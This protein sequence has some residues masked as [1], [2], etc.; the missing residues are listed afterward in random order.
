MMKNELYISDCLYDSDNLFDIP[1]LRADMQAGKLELPLVAFGAQRRTLTEARTIHFYVEDYRFENIWK[2]P[3]KIVS[4][5]IASIVEPNVSVFDTTPIAYGLHQIYKKRWIARYWQECGI[6]V[7]ADLNVSS[8]FYEYNLMGI[9]EGYNAFA[10]RGYADRLQYMEAEIEQA[11]RI[12][13]LDMPNMIVYGGGSKVHELCC[14]HSL[15][16][17]HELMTERKMND[18]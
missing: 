1:N 12:S 17:I 5:G 6:K 4:A 18:G 16:Y 7:Y 9:P 10:T 3:A 13:G 8:K 2:N 11:K 15:L 14:K